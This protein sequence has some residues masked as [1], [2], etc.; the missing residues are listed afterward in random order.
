ML[1][2][3]SKHIP[4]L[5]RTNGEGKDIIITTY[6]ALEQQNTSNYLGKFTWGRIVLGK[7]NLI[8]STGMPRL[9]CNRHAN[10]HA[11]LLVARLSFANAC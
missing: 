5:V 4:N 6:R 7:D 11:S 8:F 3:R 2:A 9:V 10:I 1:D